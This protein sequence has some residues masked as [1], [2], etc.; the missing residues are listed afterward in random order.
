MPLT[1]VLRATPSDVHLQLADVVTGTLMTLRLNGEFPR[2][3]LY[4]VDIKSLTDDEPTLIQKARPA[5]QKY[6]E[7]QLT[8]VKLPGGGKNARQHLRPRSKEQ[9]RV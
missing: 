4:C 2:S 7:E 6:N 5:F 9:A 8:A 1:R 3:H